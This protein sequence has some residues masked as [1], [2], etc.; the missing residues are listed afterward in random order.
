MKLKRLHYL[1]GLMITVFVGLHLFNHCCSIFGVATHIE[2]MDAL[3][4][5]YRNV[6]VETVLLAAVVVQII[7]GLKLFAINRKTA[8]SLFDK[9]Q[10]W[11]G[12]YLAFFLLFHVSAVLAGRYY[13]HLDTNFYFGAAG[14]NAF[15]TALFFVPY[16]ALAV[17]SFFGHVAAIHH[18]KMKH[19][20][21]GL[22]P[23]QQAKGIVISGIVLTGLI[24]YGLTDHFQGAEIPAAYHIL[25]GK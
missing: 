17:V 3:R 18:K 22:T 20:V 15:P 5:V 7:S 23:G 25:M 4:L 14:I 10:I 8:T 19:N 9:L 13:L 1:S 16:Y 6:V 24:F 21:A 12:L 2:V 11:T